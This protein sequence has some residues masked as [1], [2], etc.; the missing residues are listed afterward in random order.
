M[1][2]RCDVARLRY[3]QRVMAMPRLLITRAV[4]DERRQQ[5]EQSLLHAA[6]GGAGGAQTSKP[7]RQHGLCEILPHGL[8]TYG[9]HHP[10]DMSDA[11]AREKRR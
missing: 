2:A 3:A 9:L 4:Y 10:A 8:T 7:R 6:R 11:S 5:F 1:R